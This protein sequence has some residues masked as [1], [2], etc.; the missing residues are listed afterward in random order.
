MVVGGGFAAPA[1]LHPHLPPADGEDNNLN[2][3]HRPP[4]QYR[5]PPSQVE[6]SRSDDS[7]RAVVYCIAY[8]RTTS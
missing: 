8:A 3:H 2:A 5:Q 6:G 7:Y 4:A 1:V